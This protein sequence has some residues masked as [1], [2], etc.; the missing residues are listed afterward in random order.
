M[1][2]IEDPHARRATTEPEQLRAFLAGREE[3]HFVPKQLG[4][5]SRW[6]HFLG[7]LTGRL[8]LC[9]HTSA[10]SDCPSQSFCQI[11]YNPLPGAS[12]CNPVSLHSGS[13]WF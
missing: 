3:L 13:R 12:R 2:G 8:A 10:P 4:A 6:E 7:L 1:L 11:M 9:W 5:R